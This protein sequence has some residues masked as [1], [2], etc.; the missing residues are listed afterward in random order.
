MLP[1]PVQDARFLRRSVTE[2][3]KEPFLL[4][5]AVLV[6]SGLHQKV[7]VLLGGDTV[8]PEPQY[9]LQLLFCLRIVL[10]VVEQQ[11]GIILMILVCIGTCMYR[12]LI[13]LFR[14]GEI[15]HLL[16]QEYRICRAH[17]CVFLRIVPSRH[18][19]H[20]ARIFVI[21]PLAILLVRHPHRGRRFQSV[22]IVGV[23]VEDH[24]ELGHSEIT[25][26]Q[27]IYVKSRQLQS[28]RDAHRVLH[29]KGFQGLR[30]R[31]GVT[32]VLLPLGLADRLKNGIAHNMRRWQRDKKLT[33][34]RVSSG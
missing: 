18:Q 30:G 10:K 22:H 13:V 9:R 28:G 31:L 4:Q 25:V 14:F 5:I 12:Q 24:I 2:P 33:P 6:I 20:Q 1:H 8:G 15:D 23:H 32:A 17:L 11:Y 7:Q 29:Q 26:V 16:P 21:D 19:P 34:A 27:F 3:G